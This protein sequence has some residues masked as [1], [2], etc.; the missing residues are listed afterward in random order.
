MSSVWP[1]WAIYCTL[2]NHSKPLA[3]INL[4]KSPTF[5][6]NFCNGVKFYHFSSEIIF[7]QFLLAFGDFFLVTLMVRVSITAGR[8]VKYHVGMT[9]GI[10]AWLTSCLTGLDST[11]GIKAAKQEISNT[12]P[13][14]VS[15]YPMIWLPTNAKCLIITSRAKGIHLAGVAAW[16][17]DAPN[18]THCAIIVIKAS[19]PY[20]INWLK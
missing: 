2:G 18:A 11:K 10:P 13:Y 5:L 16:R 20:L 4:P 19:A 12:F 3:T 14:K 1:Y 9:P 7:G 15:E 6:D 17:T 8:A